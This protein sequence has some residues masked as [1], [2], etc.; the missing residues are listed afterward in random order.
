M[1]KKAKLFLV[2]PGDLVENLGAIDDTRLRRCLTNFIISF[3]LSTFDK[4]KTNDSWNDYKFSPKQSWDNPGTLST[5]GMNS[6]SEYSTER[7]FED[8]LDEFIT[9]LLAMNT[10]E[11]SEFIKSLERLTSND[12]TENNNSNIYNIINTIYYNHSDN[13]IFNSV[14]VS[15]LE[16]TNTIVLSSYNLNSIEKLKAKL[17]KEGIENIRYRIVKNPYNQKKIH[18]IMYDRIGEK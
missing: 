6:Y 4:Y 3:D 11:K 16:K 18:T 13:D 8:L 9:N 7:K 15:K 5:K 1:S 2:A 17:I 10:S 12:L 14:K